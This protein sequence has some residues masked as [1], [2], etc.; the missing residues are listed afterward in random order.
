[1]KIFTA[2][3]GH[4]LED[5]HEIP[6]LDDP[7]EISRTGRVRQKRAF[8]GGREFLDYEKKPSMD[9]ASG[10]LYVSLRRDGKK[11]TAYVHRLVAQAFNPNPDGL[12]YVRHDNGNRVANHAGNLIWSATRPRRNGRRHKSCN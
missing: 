1:V 10:Y 2:R 4:K 9:P 8:L 6:G 3:K 11:F 5:W 12:P 7:C